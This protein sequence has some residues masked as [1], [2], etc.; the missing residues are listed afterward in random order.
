MK[1]YTDKQVLD[2]AESIHGFKCIPS[3]YWLFGIRSEADVYDEFDDKFF[4]FKG[5]EFIMSLTGTTNAGSSA[6]LNYSKYNPLGTAILKSD[7]WYYDVWSPGLHKGRM[8]C[9]KQVRPMFIY[10]DNNKNRKSEEIGKIYY[11]MVGI[12]FHAS[13]YSQD[14]SFIRKLIGGWSAGC[15]VINDTKRYYEALELFETQKT[16]SYCL[17]KEF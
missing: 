3:E 17:V 4:V 13:T 10:R 12:E 15:Q 8:R 11:K 2:K 7:E 9:L 6:L 16:T 14:M 1:N 5:R